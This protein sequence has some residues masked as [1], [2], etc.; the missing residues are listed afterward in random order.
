VPPTSKIKHWRGSP[1]IPPDQDR[2]RHRLYGTEIVEVD[3]AARAAWQR[4]GLKLDR[5]H[6]Y[7]F[8]RAVDTYVEQMAADRATWMIG[9]P[10]NAEASQ[11]AWLRALQAQ[12]R[13]REASTSPTKWR[14]TPETRSISSG[15]CCRST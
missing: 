6:G 11:L 15:R 1:A 4:D 13:L 7:W 12:L 9:R 10:E 2:L 5:L 14:P 3:P 8:H